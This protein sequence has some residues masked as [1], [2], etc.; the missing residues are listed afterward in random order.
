VG[1]G[2]ARRGA[3]LPGGGV[4][5]QDDYQEAIELT[6]DQQQAFKAFERAYKKCVNS[7][8]YFYQVLDSICALNGNNVL[9]IED[10]AEL[11]SDGHKLSD[12]S[13]LNYLNY[14]EFTAFSGW[15]DDTHYVKL[16]EDYKPK[17]QPQ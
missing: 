7:G 16:R 9:G 1:A 3:G 4:M 10:R 13:N 12:E 14:P 15:A 17:E 6:R 5:T 2:R 8:I 11:K